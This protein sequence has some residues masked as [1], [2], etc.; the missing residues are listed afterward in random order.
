MP[1]YLC[2][3]KNWSDFEQ[4]GNHRLYEEGVIIV[5]KKGVEPNRH[6]VLVEGDPDGQ[7][8][9]VGEIIPKPKAD[10]REAKKEEAAAAEV[11][12]KA[13]KKK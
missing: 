3:R 13:K 2:L 4:P 5:L 9:I 1:K 6:F 8:E 11:I 10:K 12:T 7:L